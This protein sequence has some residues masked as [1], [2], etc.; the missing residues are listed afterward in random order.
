LNWTY[1]ALREISDMHEMP[2]DPVAWR[3]LLAELEML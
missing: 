3:G 1:K 2:D